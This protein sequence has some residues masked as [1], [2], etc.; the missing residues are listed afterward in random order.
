MKAIS[1]TASSTSK[2]SKI[3]ILRTLPLLLIMLLMAL[4]LPLLI[5]GMKL[6]VKPLTGIADTHHSFPAL[7]TGRSI[8]TKTWQTQFE[9]WL[10]F[11]IPL[12]SFLIRIHNQI[13]YSF[14]SKSY[15]MDS[16][17]IIGKNNTLYQMGY[18][19]KYCN[20][21]QVAYNQEQ[22]AEWVTK[23]QALNNF[24][25]KRGQRFIYIITP[26]KASYF[27]EYLPSHYQCRNAPRP[28]YVMAQRALK[29]A[30]FPYINASQIV[31]HNKPK[32]GHLL[33]PR[34]G[35][36]WTQL[37]VAI[38][39][40]DIL[41]KI[42]A[43]TKNELPQLKFSY[44]SDFEPKGSDIDLLELSNLL[45]PQENYIVPQ[46]SF[47]KL[48]PLKPGKRLKITFVGGSFLGQLIQVFGQEKLFAQM[49]YY[50]YLKMRHYH[51]ADGSIPP[52]TLFG[53][54]EEVNLNDPKTYHDIL[55]A[56]VVIFEEN[57]DN[58]Q[59]NYLTELLNTLK[60]NQRDASKKF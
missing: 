19:I 9:D 12:R 21:N 17:T 23:L 20:T 38:V 54:M 14:F 58:I 10:N 16:Q 41:K 44:T 24:F 51:M 40:P 28:D 11:K 50:F 39:I 49:D 26:S 4:P 29:T 34:G 13:Y 6:K 57:E 45:F 35:I 33:F 7:Q 2:Q 55:N 53:V 8:L 42:S 3:N 48:P 52:N 27:P 15:M 46:V 18:L 31:L 43:V 37:A 25:Q 1:I 56:D 60:L 22:F 47:T 59:S 5:C 36:H 30:A 32:Y